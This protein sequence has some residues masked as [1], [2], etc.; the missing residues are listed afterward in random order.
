MVES[1]HS[2]FFLLVEIKNVPSVLCRKLVEVKS[3]CVVGEF[4]SELIDSVTEDDRATL[5]L[6]GIEGAT[7]EGAELMTLSPSIPNTVL[8]PLLVRVSYSPKNDQAA[9]AKT[10]VANDGIDLLI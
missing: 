4:I 1:D 5:R 9:D 10:S 3:G 6:D 8:K 2:D 7:R